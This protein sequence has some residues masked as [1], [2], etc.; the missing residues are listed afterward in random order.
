M[1]N[2]KLVLATA[3]VA[4]IVTPLSKAQTST[5]LATGLNAPMKLA[6]TAE[7]N[8]VV[9]EATVVLNTGRVS[10][11][12]RSGARRTLLDGLPSGPAYPGN[13]PLGPAA[14][15][16][17]EPDSQPRRPSVANAFLHPPGCD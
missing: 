2:P 5:V 10:I 6:M 11:V 1:N 3:L 13:A 17:D 15:V 4:V 14:L 9:S 8:L 16:V 12:E 7:G